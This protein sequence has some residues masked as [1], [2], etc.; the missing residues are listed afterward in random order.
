MS[1]K[2]THE[3]IVELMDTLH[4]G[5]VQSMERVADAY[6]TRISEDEILASMLAVLG[7]VSSSVASV[8]GLDAQ[9]FAAGMHAAFHACEA[10]QEAKDAI[11][12]AASN[13]DEV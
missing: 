6:R 8:Y 13:K 4:D 1:N 5:L 3:A 12:R 11:Q 9:R 7:S 10:R 2:D